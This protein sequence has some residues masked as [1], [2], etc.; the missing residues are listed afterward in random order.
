MV[1][2]AQNFE[3]VMLRRALQDV[4]TGFYVDLGAYHPVDDSVTHWFYGRRWRGINVEPNPAF[5][6]LLTNA[7]PR[8]INLQCA[9]GATAGVAS[10]HIA[11][12][13]GLSSLNPPSR[14]E[15]IFTVREVLEVPVRTLESI[16]DEHAPPTGIDFL[17][18]DVEGYEGEVI[19]GG[20]FDRHRPRIV[21]VEATEPSSQIPSWEAWQ[22]LLLSQGYEFVWFDGLNR[23]YLSEEEGWRRR[24][25]EL[26]P[27]CFDAFV[28]ADR[29][30]L[31]EARY[32]QQRRDEEIIANNEVLMES[33]KAVRIDLARAWSLYE[34]EKAEREDLDDRLRTIYAAIEGLKQ[35]VEKAQSH[36][37]R[38][39]AGEREAM[40]R[41]DEL[42]G[43]VTFLTESRD[44]AA[45][46]AA[47][48]QARADE[49]EARMEKLFGAVTF[50]TESRDFAA[51]RAAEQQARADE[52]EARLE[53]LFGAVAFLTESRDFAAARAAEQ[54]ARADESE[55]RLEEL[56]GAVAF[57]T[58]SR[59]FAAARAAEQQARAE[60]VEA[61]LEAL[62]VSKTY[63]TE[64]LD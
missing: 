21:L 50:L 18:I 22:P 4:R 9:V 60:G 42:F 12:G 29:G 37:A 14:D 49:C 20:A 2:Y 36:A 28:L 58:E 45:A 19:Q 44:F 25:F 33:I 5:F 17:K 6:K 30:F 35:A 40:K 64:P 32:A 26:P 11:K 47:E 48:Q 39:E 7:R 57:L 34:R 3:D 43:A 52:S 31:R 15:D 55:A 56:F 61:C 13:A 53:E 1:S 46:R 24:Y 8:D 10:L 23:F 59:D 63:P 27:C 62:L 51:A 16:F 54:Q 41:I 38:A